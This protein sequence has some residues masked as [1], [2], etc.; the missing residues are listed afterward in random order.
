MTVASRASVVVS[1]PVTSSIRRRR[2]AALTPASSPWSMTLT[3][4]R[5]D[6]ASVICRP[7]EPQPRATGISREPKG[8]W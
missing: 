6:D 3:R 7:P 4:R 5:A 1:T 8:T 2:L